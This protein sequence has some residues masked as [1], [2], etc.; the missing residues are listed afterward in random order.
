M[1]IDVNIC[2]NQFPYLVIRNH[3]REQS[4]QLEAVMDSTEDILIIVDKNGN[5]VKTNR[6]SYELLKETSNIYDFYNKYHFYN[7]EGIKLRLKELTLYWLQKG[8]SF[9]YSN[10]I[11]KINEKKEYF[12]VSGTPIYDEKGNLTMEVLRWH[13]TTGYIEQLQIIEQQKKQLQIILRDTSI[14]LPNVDINDGHVAIDEPELKI[15]DLSSKKKNINKESIIMK[16]EKQQVCYHIS[17]GYVYDKKGSI[18]NAIICNENIKEPL[19]YEEIIKKQ[20]NDMYKIFDIL[21]FPMLIMSY[22]DFRIIQLNRKGYSFLEGYVKDGISFFHE[23]KNRRIFDFVPDFNSQESKNCI[24]EAC[25]SKS[26]V[27]LRNKKL[28]INGETKTFNVIYQPIFG[29]KQEIVEILIILVDISYEMKEKSKIKK[30]MRMQQEFFSFI[31]HEFRTPLTTMSST[32]QL[33]DLVYDK[34]MTQNVRKYINTI[35]RSIFQ[36]LRLVNNLLDITRAEAGY[37]KVHAKNYDI[38]AITKAIVESII[39]FAVAKDIKLKFTSAIK[40]KLIALDDEKYE[41]ILLNLLS[42]AIKF[43]SSGKCIRITLSENSNKV[44]ICVKDEGVGIPKNKQSV[45]FDRFGQS[46]SKRSRDN[47]GTG[48]GLYLVKL[49]VESMNGE[50]R[51]NSKENKGSTFIISFPDKLINYSEEELLPELTNDRLVQSLK[52]EFSNIYLD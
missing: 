15:K 37:L 43:T 32:L 27:Y 41:R 26:S 9:K 30:I 13:R 17:E 16:E 49:L 23:F 14:E 8:E 28:D 44:Y 39:P 45:I 42:N 40:E 34:E 10:V 31:T 25:K 20:R 1:N 36:Q 38:V 47:E 11:L 46:G 24:K 7:S 21:E 2:T 12:D 22:P 51:L 35:K 48:I 52:M 3:I 50:I 5:Y 33:L 4:K 29:V 18:S 19:N 6:N